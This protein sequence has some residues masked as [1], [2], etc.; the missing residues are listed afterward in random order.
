[1]V[2]LFLADGFEEIEALT[3]VDVLRR[4]GV[5]IKTVSIMKDLTAT[6]A[7]GVAV[8]ADE[9]FEDTDFVQCEMMI[10]PGGGPGTERLLAHA[11]LKTALVD[12]AA[13]GKRIAAICA[14]PMVLARHGLLKGKKA[15][16]YDGM[17]KELAEAE[18]VK[19]NVV[20]D[21]KLVTS[22]GPGTAMAFAFA[23][24]EI[25]AGETVAGR[26]RAEML[27]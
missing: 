8:I 6:G 7:H 13:A 25:L 2:Y 12:F 5:A 4:A 23:L 26:V 20:R 1:M 10:L 27:L 16:V 3:V 15:T 18:Y 14:A 19:E 11:G 22:R 24:A 17:E 9:L 21:G